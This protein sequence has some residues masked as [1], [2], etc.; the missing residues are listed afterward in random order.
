MQIISANDTNNALSYDELIPALRDMFKSGAEAPLRHH[1]EISSSGIDSTLLLM[2]A[3]SDCYGG[4]K[5][6]NVNPEN[7]AKNLPSISASYLLFDTKT[8]QHLCLMDASIMTSKRTAAASALAASYLAKPDSSR[9]LVVGA[10]KVGSE[11]P[12]AFKEVLPIQEVLVWDRNNNQSTALVDRLT[13]KG[14]NAKVAN[15]LEEGV[16][17]TDIISCA[18]LAEDPIIKGEWL[19]P[20]QHIDLIG[21][22]T[23]TMREVDDSTLKRSKIFIDTQAAVIESGEFLIPLNSGVIEKDDIG[24]SL[25]ELCSQDKTWRNS[26]DITLFKGVGHAIEDLAAASLIYNSRQDKKA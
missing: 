22:F 25:Y 7:N 20:G 13:A 2:P 11:L 1:H 6:V 16:K 10:G 15:T 8:G 14:W 12:D 23:P 17:A 5:L 18:T 4:I 26:Q 3:W 24:A 21:S 9:L 19:K